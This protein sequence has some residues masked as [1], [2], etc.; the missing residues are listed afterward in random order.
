M[1]CDAKDN[2]NALI[3]T[4]FTTEVYDSSHLL[5]PK[6]YSYLKNLTPPLGIKPV[7]V[8]LDS[9]ANSQMGTLAEDIFDQYCEKTYS[10]KTFKNRGVLILASKH[11]ELIQVRV[12][13]TCDIYC[14]MK[15]SAAGADYLEMQQET[16]YRGIDKFCP[17]VFTH[18][19]Y[20]C[21]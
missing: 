9:I 20:H 7:V 17:V 11:P 14:R 5:A 2:P 4:E 15:G 18:G 8:V 6:T 21:P 10:G 12:G 19:G 1:A 3:H 16:T 13:S